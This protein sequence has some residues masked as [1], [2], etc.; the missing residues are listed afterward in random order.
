MRQLVD[1]LG[2]AAEIRGDIFARRRVLTSGIA[3][4]VG[5]AFAA[6]CIDED[7]QPGGKGRLADWAAQ[8]LDGSSTGILTSLVENGTVYNPALRRSIDIDDYPEPRMWRREERVSNR[9][10]FMD[11]YVNRYVVPLR[12]G[13]AIFGGARMSTAGLFAGGALREVR[14]SPFSDEDLTLYEGFMHGARRLWREF[15]WAA[16]AA[17]KLPQRLRALFEQMLTG[18][19]E[20]AIAVELGLS[21]A[22][23][24]TYV[25]QLYRALGVASRAELM[26]RARR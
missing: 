20:K 1:L 23:V 2:E 16:E 11:E 12:L 9:E 3:R 24:H 7:F 8:G 21:Y 25:R 13:P 6:S 19:S 5:V 15:D 22:S 10:W 17:R 4:I 18:R 14:D 26:A